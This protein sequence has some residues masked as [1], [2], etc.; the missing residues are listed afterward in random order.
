MLV[1]DDH[2]VG[3]ALLHFEGNAHH[4]EGHDDDQD[5]PIHEDA[6]LASLMH[7]VV[8]DGVF[9]PAMLFT[10]SFTTLKLDPTR[11]TVISDLGYPSPF[12]DGLERP[13]R[14]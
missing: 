7:I 9:S 10:S 12:L 1:A 4:H 11:P 5:D 13:P 8:D 3:H 2:E 6:S 14:C